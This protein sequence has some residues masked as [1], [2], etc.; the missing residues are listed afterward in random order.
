MG[1]ST[2]RAK[3]DMI[4]WYR[5]DLVHEVTLRTIDGRWWFDPHNRTMV[6]EILG[7]LA[8]AQ[9][10]T[11]VRVH[12]FVFMSNHYHG[13]Y[14]AEFPAQFSRFLCLFHAAVARIVNRHWE[15]SGRVWDGRATVIPIFPN[16][17]S[18]LQRLDYLLAQNVKV[19]AGAHPR[20]WIGACSTPWLLDG[21]PLVGLHRDQTA[22]TLAGR[23]GRDP[24]D[25]AA[26]TEE[27]AVE[28]TPLPCFVGRTDGEWR[29]QVAGIANGIAERWGAVV[30]DECDGA[31]ATN[32]DEAIAAV[33]V[34]A[35]GFEAEVPS[36]LTDPAERVRKSASP[37]R[38]AVPWVHAAVKAD[39]LALEAERKAFQDE[40]RA[41]AAVLR[42][43]AAKLATG[44]QVQ[45]A[46]FPQWS[47]PPAAPSWPLWPALLA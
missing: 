34:D 35:S 39:R 28:L 18:Q 27:V 33:Q 15:R 46:P 8:V 45:L 32:Q 25:P 9:R 23:N 44:Q 40:Y 38:K 37:E 16:A 3:V 11:A 47:F 21:M 14:S 24:G 26:Y 4:R 12:A 2:A 10:A 19:G 31:A 36:D 42:S 13:L 1:K 7:A 5:P 30:G 29:E 20:D 6:K 17:E 43:Q 22:L 41:A